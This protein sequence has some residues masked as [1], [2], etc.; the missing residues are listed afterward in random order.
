[1]ATLHDGVTQGV[2]LRERRIGRLCWMKSGFAERQSE[3]FSSAF[4]EGLILPNYLW[5]GCARIEVRWEHESLGVFGEEGQQLISGD[6]L[7]SYLVALRSVLGDGFGR[8]KLPVLGQLNAIAFTLGLYFSP[9]SDPLGQLRKQLEVLRV[10]WQQHC[11]DD[12]I[13]YAQTQ[14][15]ALFSGKDEIQIA[16]LAI[17]RIRTEQKTVGGTVWVRMNKNIESCCS[18][19][20][21]RLPT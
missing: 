17:E 20:S 6:I 7:L 12:V 19:F 8:A 11:S 9:D 5:R 3:D 13:R 2:L 15:A 16:V 18:Q 21:F 10:L 4:L 1:M 14:L